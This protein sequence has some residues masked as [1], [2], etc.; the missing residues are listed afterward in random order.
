MCRSNS[1]DAAG[2]TSLPFLSPEVLSRSGF[3]SRPMALAGNSDAPYT[4]KRQKNPR[5]GEVQWFKAI[6][7]VCVGG[8]WS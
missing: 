3:A 2:D 8:S 5:A 1:L 7:V 6:V 4:R